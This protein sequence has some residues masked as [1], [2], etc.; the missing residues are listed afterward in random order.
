MSGPIASLSSVYTT[1]KRPKAVSDGIV[2]RPPKWLSKEAKKIYKD[3]I[4]QTVKLG[5]AG[6]ADQHTVAIYSL[7]YS[8]LQQFAAKKDRELTEERMLNELQ[9]SVLG[10]AKELGLTPGG[11]A[12]MRVAKMEDG[13]SPLD[14][15][16]ETR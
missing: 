7:Q 5:I 11:R 1:D 9:S 2:P 12:R 4:K 15:L 6:S 14:D 13:T 3:T 8:R 16:M 10:L